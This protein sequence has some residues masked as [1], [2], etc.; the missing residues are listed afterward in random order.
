MDKSLSAPAPAPAPDSFIFIICKQLRN[1]TVGE[2]VKGCGCSVAHRSSMMSTYPLFW[3]L[4]FDPGGF[5]VFFGCKIC[6][7]ICHHA[8]PQMLLIRVL[9]HQVRLPTCSNWEATWCRVSIVVCS[10]E[11]SVA[12]YQCKLGLMCGNAAF[13]GLLKNTLLFLKQIKI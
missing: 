6:V 1:L 8:A 3:W 4:A 2:I 7:H 12:K 5:W 13:N 9:T 10:H 11:I